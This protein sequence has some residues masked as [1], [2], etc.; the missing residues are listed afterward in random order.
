MLNFLVVF[1]LGALSAYAVFLLREGRSSFRDEERINLLRKLDFG[2]LVLDRNAVCREAIGDLN[3]LLGWP[4]S[5]SPLGQSLTSIMSESA[6]RGD[7]GPRISPNMSV[8]PD[9]FMSANIEDIYLETPSGRVLGI[10][11]FELPDRGWILSYTDM[12]HMKEQTRMLYRA[13]VELAKSEARAKEL[14]HE[15]EAAN[16]AKTAFLA[17]MSHEIRTPMNGV[18]GMSEMLCETQLNAEQR[19]YSETI[20]QSADALLGII[21]DILDFSKIEAGRM[22][23]REEKFDLMTAV[24]D[25]LMLV[26]PKATEKG[27][28]IALVYDPNLPRFFLGDVMRLRQV[29]INLA[30]NAAKF[31]L[32]GKVVLRVGGARSGDQFNAR[33]EVEDTGI[34]IS[35][36][37]ISRIFSEFTRVDHS[38]TRHFEGTG[39]GLAITRKLV[40][41]MDGSLTVTSTIGKGT[42]FCLSISFPI[43]Y[44]VENDERTDAAVRATVPRRILCVDALPETLDGIDAHLSRIGNVVTTTPD[45]EQALSMLDLAGET[46]GGYDLILIDGELAAQHLDALTNRIS[47]T[48]CGTRIIMMTASERT[49]PSLD[50]PAVI[51]RLL[52]PLRLSSIGSMIEDIVT[53]LALDDAAPVPE[54]PVTA[55]DGMRVTVLVADDNRTNRMVVSKM[56]KDSPVDLHFAENGR[57]AVEMFM[58]IAPELI[59][60][61][62]SM[63]EMNGMDACRAI[64]SHEQSE[65]TTETPIV[66]L[67]ANAM[68]GDREKCYDAGMNDYL[69]KPIRKKQLLDMIE[70][71]RVKIASDQAA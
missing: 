21:N 23:L 40:E 15:A 3:R 9:F 62:L 58:E 18:I 43:A 57:I 31:T 20:R 48:D 44:D 25:V 52:K 45:I 30:G 17:A 29:L 59:F 19:S 35:E 61:D 68:E 65:G 28:E 55:P 36:V 22:N 24:E 46:R 32:E 34:G 54:Q 70:T 42:T 60:M 6:N 4:D 63:P 47:H 8:D 37:N 16:R 71:Y 27:V 10:A 11:I 13:Q 51:G 66:A 26:S 50:H 33:L 39:L 67:T 38:G 53:P 64:R 49:T 2:A 1:T 69:S 56:L 5:W 7:F 14:A 12:T 41:I